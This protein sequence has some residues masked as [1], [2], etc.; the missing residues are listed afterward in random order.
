MK[1]DIKIYKGQVLCPSHK[2][3]ETET[4]RGLTE[5]QKSTIVAVLERHGIRHLVKN[6]S[7]NV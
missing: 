6:V 4:I 5:T 3:E 2:A 7:G 1:F